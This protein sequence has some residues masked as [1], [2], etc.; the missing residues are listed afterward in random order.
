MKDRTVRFQDGLARAVDG[1]SRAFLVL[2]V[3]PLALSFFFPLWRIEMWAPQYPRGLRLEIY[4]HRLDGGNHGHDIVEINNLNHY[5]G[6]QPLAESRIPELG[7]IPF[8]FGILALLALRAAAIGT[9][10][11]LIDL[12]VLLIYVTVFFLAR[13]VLM[14][15]RYG[16]E[17]DPTAAV[18]VAPFMPAVVGTKQIANFTTRSV[19][20]V[21]TLL[22]GVF[23]LGVVWV[24]TRSLFAS[25]QEVPA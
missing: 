19:P 5:I 4:S 13:F 24:T 15:Y 23:A 9:G 11:D 14:L 18:T 10:R 3:L 1:R 25:R 21:G 6:M 2:L 17:L 7:W 12:S 16:H 22:V 8:A 20:D